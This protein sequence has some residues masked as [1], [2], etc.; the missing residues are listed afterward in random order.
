[1]NYKPT[2][3]ER[4]R[5]NRRSKWRGITEDWTAEDV[6][7]VA[8]ILDGEG[9]IGIVRAK[10]PTSRGGIW[11]RCGI[12]VG[13]NSP[14]VL[15]RL[16]VLLHG[17]G[18]R[19]PVRLPGNR[20]PYEVINV[21]N[22]HAVEEILIRVLP[23]LVT[24]MAQA[25]VVL[26]ARTAAESGYHDAARAALEDLCQRV[27]ELNSATPNG[28][29][30]VPIGP[31][32]KAWLAGLI[33]GEGCVGIHR[34]NKG[35]SLLLRIAIGMTDE[36]I[37]RRAHEVAGVG[38]FGIEPRPTR[39]LYRWSVECQKALILL[40]ELEP[41]LR[42]KL[43]HVQIAKTFYE[44]GLMRRGDY[45]KGGITP[46]RRKIQDGCYEAMRRLNVRGI[47]LKAAGIKP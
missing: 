25:K 38:R 11:Y 1:M 10:S 26:A 22:Q 47:G 15:D 34:A 40:L 13:Q 16:H 6:A 17:C 46:E 18:T 12:T 41:H 29:A 37:V 9:W 32:D 5:E 30:D 14:E 44:H 36:V 31:E 35:R 45:L 7:W 8:A 21:F 27:Q 23:R 24:K 33:D 42:R 4:Y 43:P 2:D 20:K 19:V 3:G 39:T 28:Y